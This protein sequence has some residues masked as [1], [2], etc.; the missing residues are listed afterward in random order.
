MFDVIFQI[1]DPEDMQRY[2]VYPEFSLTIDYFIHLFNYH[3]IDLT[4]SRGRF[5]AL[6]YVCGI[7]V[8]SVFFASLFTYIANV[9]IN[10]VRIDVIK[11]LRTSAFDRITK[12]H[13][14]YFSDEQKGRYPLKNVK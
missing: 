11:K 14:G 7:L 4:E 2:S 9:I 10:Y 12:L 6:V 8:S 1:G 13:L 5:S 3:L